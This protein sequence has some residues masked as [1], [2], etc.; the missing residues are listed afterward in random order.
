MPS[1]LLSRGCLQRL[2]AHDLHAQP[3]LL[4]DQRLDHR[5]A[6]VAVPDLVR[7]GLLL[8]Q[9]PLG[10]QVGHHLLAR[11]KRR[12]PVVREPRHVHAAVEVHSIDD[13]EGMALTYVVVHR[14]VPRR[15]F[16]RPCAEILLD[17]IVAD[18]RQLAAD[19]RQD[20]CL[21]D[22]S[23]VSVVSGI[24][25]HTGVGEHRLR[26]HRCDDHVTASFN[27]VTD[28]VQGVVMLLPLD[29]EV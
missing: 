19:Q 27:R 21:A 16:E 22:Q 29:L 10:L 9:K 6:P 12:Q 18:D 14:I 24:D 28:E 20:R 25:R 17:C 11:F 26:P 3:P 5:I 1:H 15:D 7:V 8:D 2:V 13:L 23:F 4:A